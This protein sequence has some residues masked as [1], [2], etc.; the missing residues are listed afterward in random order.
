MTRDTGRSHFVRAA[1]ESV[2]YQTVDVLQAMRADGSWIG[3]LRVDGG[4]ARNDW[5]CQFLSNILNLSVDRPSN[6]E[7]TALG[8]AYLAGLY[9]GLY[10]SLDEISKNWQSDKIFEVT[11]DDSVR[12]ELLRRWGKAVDLVAQFACDNP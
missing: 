5:F 12:H 8:A 7:T 2:A 6:T 11:M 3:R 9:T 1:L 10:S 4:M